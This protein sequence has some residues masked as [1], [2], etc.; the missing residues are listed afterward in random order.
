VTR[1]LHIVV[2]EARTE[3]LKAVRLPAY[4]L[5]TLVFPA[6][7]YVLFG[8]ALGGG[9]VGS[10]GAVTMLATYGAFGVIGAAFYSFGVGVAVERGQG[11][12][13]LKRATPAPPGAWMAARMFVSVVFATAI[14][15]L[16]SILGVSL[17]HVRVP[18]AS[19]LAMA[20]ILVAGA[21]PFCAF[22]LA[23]GYLAGPNSAP[24]VVN[25][26]YLPLSFASGLWIPIEALPG[27]FKD[28]ALGL[29][30]YHYA[31]LALGAIGSGRG[32]PAWSHVAVLAGFTA[33]SVALALWAYRRDEG[34]T[35]G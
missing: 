12:L 1:D 19:W 31:Q 26:L 24:A 8:V 34:K 9:T 7:F 11:W 25:L 28:L 21:L 6:M 33:V 4:S 22:G 30:P 29:P 3:L 35:Y 10:R 14:V 15:L 13:L 23:L 18:L 2:A 27:F 16:L 32:G 20:A 5:P 17:A